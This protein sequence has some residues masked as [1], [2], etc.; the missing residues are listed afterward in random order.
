MLTAGV[1]HWGIGRRKRAGYSASDGTATD[2]EKRFVCPTDAMLVAERLALRPPAALPAVPDRVE[3]LGIAA[4]TVNDLVL[5]YV[6]LHG[7]ATLAGLHAALKLS[8]PVLETVFHQFRQQ[9]VLE[10]KGMLGNDYSFTLTATGRTLAAARNEACQYAGPAPVS[11]EQY[12]RVVKAQAAH[13]RPPSRSAI[14]RQ[15]AALRPLPLTHGRC[16]RAS[17]RRL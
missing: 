3:E 17:V 7:G 2:D 4:S 6:W 5:R 13:I 10:V 11:L 16:R 14:Q 15:L 8:F 1:N 9:H 12:H